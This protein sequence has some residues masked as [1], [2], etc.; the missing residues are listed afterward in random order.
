ME[1]SNLFSVQNEYTNMTDEELVDY[2]Q[3]GDK[4]AEGTLINRYSEI[5][6]M[7]A[8]KFFIIGAEKEDIVNFI[9]IISQRYIRIHTDFSNRPNLLLYRF[10]KRDRCF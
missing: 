9:V 5:V 4:H 8:R 10:K 3:K 2:A 7:K 6:N 1:K